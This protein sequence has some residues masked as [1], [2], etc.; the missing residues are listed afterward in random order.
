MCEKVRL[1]RPVEKSWVF[2]V[3]TLFD[4]GIDWRLRRDFQVRL[5]GWAYG[6]QRQFYALFMECHAKVI[7]KASQI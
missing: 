2:R 5:M 4:A 3:K 1:L 7:V 6:E